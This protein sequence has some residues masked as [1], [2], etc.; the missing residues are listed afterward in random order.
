MA[1]SWA[2]LFAASLFACGET[3]PEPRSERSH[4]H[5]GLLYPHSHQ[6]PSC[7]GGRWTH[8]LLAPGPG[9]GKGG[10]FPR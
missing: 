1:V 6:T 5:Q 4:G 3:P 2:F 8:L 9:V 10:S 7:T